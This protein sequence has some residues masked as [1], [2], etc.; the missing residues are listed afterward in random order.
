[1]RYDERRHGMRR[2]TGTETRKRRGE[3]GKGRE[4]QG[5]RRGG[6]EEVRER[7]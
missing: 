2:G 1:V 6:K 5:K 3:W 4:G 7:M